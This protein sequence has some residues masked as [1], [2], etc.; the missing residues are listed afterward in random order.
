MNDQGFSDLQK[1]YLEGFTSGLQIAQRMRGLPAPAASAQP[2][3]TGPSGE[4][5]PAGPEVIHFEAQNRFTSEGKKLVA[6]EKAKRERHPLDRWDE[7]L[8]RAE[9]GEFPKGT[10]VFC[11]KFFGLFYVAP[12]QDSYMCRLRLPNGILS[13]FQFRGIADLAE[14]YAGGYSHVTTRANLQIR[15]IKAQD[16]PSVLMGLYE[17]GIINRGAGADNIRNVTG[18]PTAGIDPQEFIDTR[19]LARELHYYILNHR[20][21]Y[22]LPRKF[23]IAFDGGGTIGVLEDTNDIGF[24]AVRVPDGK[25]VE[26]GV[27]FHLQLGGIT[28]HSDFGRDTGVLLKPEQ[29]IPVAAAVVRVF[30]EQGDR[31]DR[32]KA[33]LKYVLDR[34]GLEKYL[35]EAE[36]H[37]PFK[38]IQFPLEDC[39]PRPP[40]NKHA[41]IGFHPQKQAGLY[42][43]GVA[44]PVGKLT[45]AQM[46]GIAAIAERY[47]SGTLRLT[48]WQN[49]LISD[50][51]EQDI[52]A[53]KEAIQ[54]LDLAWRANSIRA[55]LVACT[56]NTGCKFSAANTKYHA[57]RI[58]EYLEQGIELDQPINIHLTGCHHS[59]AQHYIGDIGLLACKI[60]R[61]DDQEVEGYHIFV[62]GGYGSE[63]RLAHAI[64][65]NVP[66]DEAPAYLKTLLECYLKHRLGP[67]EGFAVFSQRYPGEQ[68]K[69]LLEHYSAEAA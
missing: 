19:P 44:L 8:K 23:N 24:S 61:G 28:G 26:S 58:A 54:D 30:I 49:L 17:L 7:L 29:C 34:W 22:G 46:R 65:R 45:V 32:T 57:E 66:A 68:F 47:G 41:H 35:Q 6:E 18:S 43:V 64:R 62:G 12:A 56:G 52:A 50:I 48:V 16:G 2:L 36:K 25:A 14:R 3:S 5:A 27:Y 42:Y 9:T 59:C 31:T 39:E 67:Q 37:L 69:H 60:A 21:F 38:L 1:R 55:G 51:R 15:E 4:T 10:D 13:S 11:T 63:Q 20:E 53:V 33:R 40:V